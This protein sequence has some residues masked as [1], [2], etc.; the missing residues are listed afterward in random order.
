M[1]REQ[2]GHGYWKG[3]ADAKNGKLDSDANVE[4]MYWIANMCI[5]NYP[6]AESRSLFPVREWIYYARF[7]GMSQTYAKKIYDH[8]F[9]VNHY[10]FRSSRT[11]TCYV[12]E[13]CGKGWN[14]DY[15]VLPL[16]DYKKEEWQEIADGLLER[17]RKEHGKT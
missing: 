14:E 1:S 2:W 3:V 15:F 11:S 17:I 4:T 7:C 8:I 16:L 6:K 5:S 13:G 9:N 10:N 12:T